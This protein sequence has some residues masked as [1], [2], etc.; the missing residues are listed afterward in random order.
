MGNLEKEYKYCQKIIKNYSKVFSNAFENLSA[1]KR[2]ALWSVYALYYCVD[3]SVKIHKDIELL[4][5]IKQDI[6][7]IYNGETKKF[8]SNTKI[9]RALSHTIHL[10]GLPNLPIELFIK[11]IEDDFIFSANDTNQQLDNYCYG[12]SGVVGELVN[13]IFTQEQSESTK[14]A[15]AEALSIELGKVMQLTKVLRNVGKDYRNGKIYLSNETLDYYN[16]DL[17]TIYYNGVTPN[18]AHL[19]ESYANLIERKFMYILGR[20]FLFDD[21]IQPIIVL[22][23]KTYQGLLEEVRNN[24]YDITKHANLSSYKKSKI[25][26]KVMEA[27]DS[28]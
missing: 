3:E 23:I 19:W 13:P 28:Q 14:V 22:T 16:V 4:N 11:T 24:L 15:E 5:K 2:N 26:R 8:Y 20:L 12:S 27:Y 10:Y 7:Q 6:Q 17:D 18:Y 21:D 1:Q 25:Y 9:M